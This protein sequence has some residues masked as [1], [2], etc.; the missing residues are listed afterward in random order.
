MP[1]GYLSVEREKAEM[2]I[3][4]KSTTAAEVKKVENV[5]SVYDGGELRHLDMKQQNTIRLKLKERDDLIAM[6][7]ME[8]ERFSSQL[9]RLNSEHTE[10]KAK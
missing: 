7:K 9:E 6:L 5:Q 3:V 4:K 10:L 1:F 2:E 8:N